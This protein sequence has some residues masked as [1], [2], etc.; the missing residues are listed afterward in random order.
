MLEL[1]P[2]GEL[3]GRLAKMPNGQVS[4]EEANFFAACTIEALQHMHARDVLYRDLKPEN[5]LIDA[6]GYIKV[7]DFGF[8]KKVL[9]GITHTVCLTPEYVSP[10]MALGKGYFKD[11]DYWAFGV[12]VYEMVVGYTPFS[13]GGSDVNL[14]SV[15][16]AIVAGKVDYPPVMQ[17]L[18]KDVVQQLLRRQ[19]SKRLGN[20]KGGADDIKAHQWFGTTDFSALTRCEVAT[21]W[22]PPISSSLDLSNFDAYDEDDD[23]PTYDGEQSIFEGF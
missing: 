5:L 20:L 13:G 16:R 3:F 15:F 1:V 19:V 10:E 14:M 7:V 21:P 8:A 12:L 2:G 9:T 18:T 11:V 4:D 23:I 17:P 22:T 6:K